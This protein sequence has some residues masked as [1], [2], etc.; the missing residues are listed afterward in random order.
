MTNHDMCLS[1]VSYDVKGDS[2]RT[3]LMTTACIYEAYSVQSMLHCLQVILSES[4]VFK[5]EEL[6]KKVTYNSQ[7]FL[8]ALTYP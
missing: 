6:N 7:K 2:H 3:F 5:I 4:C 8:N 1:S